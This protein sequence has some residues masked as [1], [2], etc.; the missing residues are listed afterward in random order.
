MLLSLT[1]EL[2]ISTKQLTSWLKTNKLTNS[3][4]PILSYETNTRSGT[5]EFSIWNLKVHY[6]VH[7]SPPRIHT[8]SHMNL[9]HI[10]LTHGAEPF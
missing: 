9:I 2:S 7:K 4:K 5:E 6:R 3:M 1:F 8:S 10:L